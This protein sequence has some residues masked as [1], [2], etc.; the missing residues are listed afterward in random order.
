MSECT[1]CS[2]DVYI[3]VD[4]DITLNTVFDGTIERI[5]SIP[6]CRDHYENLP[7]HVRLSE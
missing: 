5:I 1:Y 7:G 2:S 4:V 6:V 3:T